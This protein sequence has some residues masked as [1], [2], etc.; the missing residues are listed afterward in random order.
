MRKDLQHFTNS[1]VNGRNCVVGVF[2]EL[3][4]W[5][6]TSQIYYYP[7]TVYDVNGEEV[8]GQTLDCQELAK[9]N[10]E[11]RRIISEKSKRITELEC[12][13]NDKELER[14]DTEL[15]KEITK[16]KASL[17]NE[18][19][20]AA[21]YLGVATKTHAVIGDLAPCPGHLHD[22]VQHLINIIKLRDEEI[23]IKNKLLD[24]WRAGVS[25]DWKDRAFKLRRRLA[26]VTG[27]M[28]FVAENSEKFLKEIE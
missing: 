16:L 3:H 26:K 4:A 22:R 18:R 1:S 23:S 8:H 7:S 15:R 13:P 14:I 25:I 5:C 10:E 11:L 19:S 24:Q 27:M 9:E 20:N 21:F 6:I 28:H 17:A 12:T 2:D